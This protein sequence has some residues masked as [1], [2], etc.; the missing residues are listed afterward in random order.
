MCLVWLR[1]GHG[2]QDILV[3]KAGSQHWGLFIHRDSF[4]HVR[5]TS[6][7]FRVNFG[8]KSTTESEDNK[9]PDSVQPQSLPAQKSRL[10]VNVL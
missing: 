8:H 9:C 5:I 7:S 2:R 6:V 1:P 3:L 10:G 4:N